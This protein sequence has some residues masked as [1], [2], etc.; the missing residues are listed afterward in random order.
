MSNYELF[1]DWR[2]YMGE[3]PY[4]HIDERKV[5]SG[6]GD[7]R[8]YGTNFTLLTEKMTHIKPINVAGYEW[9]KTAF[10]FQLNDRIEGGEFK[11]FFP[12]HLVWQKVITKGGVDTQ[13]NNDNIDTLRGAQGYTMGL[14]TGYGITNT[15][16]CDND[17]ASV[18]DGAWSSVS[19]GPM[20]GGFNIG[21]FGNNVIEHGNYHQVHLGDWGK[22]GTSRTEIKGFANLKPGITY[23]L[24]INVDNAIGQV[25]NKGPSFWAIAGD[26]KE[27]SNEVTSIDDF[28]FDVRG[29][30]VGLNI[31]QNLGG[32]IPNRCKHE[33]AGYTENDAESGDYQPAPRHFQF[34][35]GHNK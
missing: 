13:Y 9:I 33:S 28:N 23:T 8:F 1:E 3:P 30:T 11:V 32:A 22:Q 26:T 6:P 34:Q 15:Q 29:P 24:V 17:A 2:K 35:A 16:V 5:G 25:S 18:N 19:T 12:A 20:G 10:S 31:V 14:W 27:N 21:I 7:K 4:K